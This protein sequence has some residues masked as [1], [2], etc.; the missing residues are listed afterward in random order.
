MQQDSRFMPK[1]VNGG[2]WGLT[3]DCRTLAGTTYGSAV[4]RQLPELVRSFY[5]M[6][7]TWLFLWNPLIRFWFHWDLSF[8]GGKGNITRNKL[9]TWTVIPKI[10]AS[11]SIKIH[12]I[13]E[14]GFNSVDTDLISWSRKSLQ[15]SESWHVINKYTIVVIKS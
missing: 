8:F 3:V 5:S 15:C 13:W 10:W 9:L 1:N 7:C 6:L 4:P 12:S 14:R 2:I 11:W